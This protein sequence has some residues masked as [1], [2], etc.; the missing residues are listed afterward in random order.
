M[1]SVRK[2]RIL[3]IHNVAKYKW[4]EQLEV[5]DKM[6][7]STG[8]KIMKAPLKREIADKFK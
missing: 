5:I 4:S 6:P 8:G 7:V 2:P 3:G 1:A